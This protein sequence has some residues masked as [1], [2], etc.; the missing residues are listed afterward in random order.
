MIPQTITEELVID[1]Y[2]N[3]VLNSLLILID[4][5]F[6]DTLTGLELDRV[7]GRLFFIFGEIQRDLGDP[8]NAS[9]IPYFETRRAIEICQMDGQTRN[10]VRSWTIPLTIRSAAE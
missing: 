8:L 5:P 9:L 6:R 7:A 1:I 3:P 4:R 2:A 10:P